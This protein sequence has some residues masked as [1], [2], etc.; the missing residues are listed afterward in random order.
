MAHLTPYL[1]FNGNC[2]EAMEFYK[3]VFGG[4][5]QIQTFGQAPVNASEAD[6]SRVMHAQLSSGNFMLMASDGMPDRPVKFG[7]S[8]SLSVHTQSKDETDALF[9]KLSEGGTITMPLENTFWGAYF[10]ML[11]DKFGIHWL[12]NF[13][14]EQP[15]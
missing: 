7:D 2:R 9:K 1:A 11:I 6:K 3:T 12:F 8:V 5:L 10:G 14:Q 15:K 4:E 13:Q